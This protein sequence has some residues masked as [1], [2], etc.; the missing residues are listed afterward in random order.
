[1]LGLCFSFTRFFLKADG[2]RLR[3]SVVDSGVGMS[4]EQQA[5][6]FT[7]FTQVLIVCRHNLDDYKP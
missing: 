2:V 6:L 4:T 5:K 1:M 7:P 3:I